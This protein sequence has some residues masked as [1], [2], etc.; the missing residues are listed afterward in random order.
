MPFLLMVF[1]TLVC[2]PD[3]D[4]WSEP[5]LPAPWNMEP[6]VWSALLTGLSMYVPLVYAFFVTRQVVRPLRRDARLRDELARRYERLRFIH[7]FLLLGC[8]SL[9][10]GVGGWGWSVNSFWRTEPIGLLPVAELVVLAPFLFTMVLSWII[11]YDAENAL[12]QAAQKLIEDDPLAAFLETPEEFALRKQNQLA[13]REYFGGR[14]SYVQF[15]IR[16]KLAL[17]SVPIIL[18]LGQKELGRHLGNSDWVLVLNFASIALM[19]VV[20]ITMPLLVRFVLGLKPMP[21]GPMRARLSKTAK[22]LRFR[23]SDVLVWNTRKGIANAMVVGI[24]RWPRYVVF[25]DRLL[26]DFSPDEVE[27]VFGHEVGHVKHQHMLYYFVFL[28]VSMTVLGL[29]GQLLLSRFISQDTQKFELLQ[30]LPMVGMVMLYIFVVFGFISRRCERQADIFGCRTVSCNQAT[31]LEHNENVDLA[32]R[33]AG[34]CPTGIRTFIR[35]L[36]KVAD[37]NGIS[38][39]RPGLLQSWQHST[40]ARRVAFLQQMISDPTIEPVFQR[41][42]T[43]VKWG[44]FIALSVML[45]AVLISGSMAAASGSP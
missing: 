19:L 23:C 26:H 25:T 14:W 18:L 43:L 22:R 27:A 45:A 42:V 34:L 15:Q 17:V 13:D 2:L 7:Q 16:Q 5:L 20:F 28:S 35:A 8:F 31:C 37:V 40:I 12:H 1:L 33:G 6:V 38:R 32:P 21:D 3:L 24:L 36:E 41:R 9:A 29:M 10:L 30:T 4:L 39:D 44:M 11:F